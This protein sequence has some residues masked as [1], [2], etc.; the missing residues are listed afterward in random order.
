MLDGHPTFSVITL[1]CRANQY[2]SNA[3]SGA[4]VKRG[5]V[6]FTPDKKTDVCIINT[7]AVTQESDRKSKQMIRRAANLSDH[8]VV[9]GCFAEV[10]KENVQAIDGVDLVI[11]N[12]NKS[13]VADAVYDLIVFGRVVASSSDSFE[14]CDLIRDPKAERVRT[15]IKIE[16]GCDNNCAYCII[17]KA[18]GPVRSKSPDIILNEVQSLVSQGVKEIILTGIEISKYGSDLPC[19][20][21]LVDII[22]EISKEERVERISLGS[23][24]P[25][26][27][28][29]DVI[30]RLSSVFKLTR[31]FHL[32]L[33]SGCT[34]TLKAMRRRYNAEQFTEIVETI[35]TAIPD[36]MISVDIIAGFPGESQADFDESVS[37][38]KRI[39]PL[40]IHSFPFSQRSGTEAAKMDCQVPGNIKKERNRIL[41]DL[42]DSIAR[43]ILE[44]YVSIHKYHPVMVLCEC[45]EKNIGIGHSEHY[46]EVRFHCET[47]ET[48]NMIKINTI[49]IGTD[50]SGIFIIGEEC[51][52]Q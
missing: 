47:D 18:R 12:K 36:A 34:N 22:E 15:Y 46:V 6:L 9:T 26:Y 27:L 40:H 25:K 31:H 4:L 20:L 35:K 42:N 7:C 2:E 8:V 17:P 24:D 13:A 1:G 32:S 43:S 44:N 10:S 38:L 16:D 51:L 11:G 19:S 3:I 28:S 50:S 33:Q 23:L 41:C 5:F 21:Q 29:Y 48:G 37:L 14:N 45:V 52:E 39:R 30:S 49:G